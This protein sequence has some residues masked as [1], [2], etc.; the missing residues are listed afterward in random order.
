MPL[1]DRA[2]IV[3]SLL[4]SMQ[5]VDPQIDEL[6]KSEVERRIAEYEAGGVELIPGEA[7]FAKIRARFSK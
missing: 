4:E 2:E 6:W 5:P 7:V 1:E 3:D